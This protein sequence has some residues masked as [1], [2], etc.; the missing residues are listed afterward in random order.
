MELDDSDDGGD[1]SAFDADI[2]EEGQGFEKGCITKL[3]QK[4][5]S[6]EDEIDAT[7]VQPELVIG[8]RDRK[9][10]KKLNQEKEKEEAN[11]RTSFLKGLFSRKSNS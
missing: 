3:K 6:G 10:I 1:V 5:L 8:F 7:V 4:I 9:Q 2:I 11:S